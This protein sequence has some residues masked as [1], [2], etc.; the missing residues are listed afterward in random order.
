MPDDIK[1][2]VIAKTEQEFGKVET[3]ISPEELVRLAEEARRP[4]P[5]VTPIP[6]VTPIPP[7]EAAATEGDRWPKS[8]KKNGLTP[9]SP[10][11]D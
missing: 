4:K 7:E 2:F 6:V 5:I 11:T 10:R 3:I 1:P 9:E 8:L